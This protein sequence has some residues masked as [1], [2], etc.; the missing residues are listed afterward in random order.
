LVI[1][2]NCYFLLLH[3]LFHFYACENQSPPCSAKVRVSI[4]ILLFFCMCVACTG[5][6][7]CFTF[8]LKEQNIPLNWANLYSSRDV[9]HVMDSA[10]YVW[11]YYLVMET[12]SASKT[13]CWFDKN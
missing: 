12:Y 8:W 6:A 11:C 1:C 9:I 5:T 3:F 7:W 13:V 4:V 2:L 10:E